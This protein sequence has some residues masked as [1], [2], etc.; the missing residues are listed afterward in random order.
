[1]TENF[2]LLE[3]TWIHI[4]NNLRLSDFLTL[5]VSYL[6]E[7]L[8]YLWLFCLIILFDFK[9][10][11]QLWRALA[12]KDVSLF[13]CTLTAL[14]VK[15]QILDPGLPSAL[16]LSNDQAKDVH[17]TTLLSNV[18]LPPCRPLLAFMLPL[19]ASDF[20]VN[21][22]ELFYKDI[23]GGEIVIVWTGWYCKV[24]E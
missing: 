20:S 21:N 16:T 7:A 19:T 11:I 3:V 5:K 15:G 6:V 13:W 8:I 24:S 23:R 9:V 14:Y 2:K 22:K 12:L 10:F 17:N 18:V 4:L 1:M